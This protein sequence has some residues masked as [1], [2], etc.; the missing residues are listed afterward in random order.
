MEG[1]AVG[2]DAQ[3]VSIA[4]VKSVQVA[5]IGFDLRQKKRIAESGLNELPTDGLVESSIAFS[6]DN[7]S[8]DSLDQLTNA[9]SLQSGDYKPSETSPL[10][11]RT[12]KWVREW[13]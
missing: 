4:E 12:V 10:F 11:L 6:I 9:G 13:S 5:T 7:S 3:I 1:R 2:R 8:Q